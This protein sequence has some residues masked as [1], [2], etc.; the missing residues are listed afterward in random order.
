MLRFFRRLHIRRLIGEKL[1]PRQ[2][3]WIDRRVSMRRRMSVRQ[4]ERHEAIVR[5][6]LGRCR[7]EGCEGLEVTDEIRT[8]IAGHA[9]V[10]LLGSD[11]YYFD[12]VG[13]IIVF[14]GTIV[15]S[16]GDDRLTLGEAWPNGGI[17]L[18]W[19]EVRATGYH[20]RGRNVVIHE[21]AH[22][23]DGLDG[24]MGGSLHFSRREDQLRWNEISGE[25]FARLCE[26]VEDGYDTLL[27]PYGATNMAEFFAVTSEAFFED[28]WSLRDEHP[29]LYAMLELY[30]G[31]DPRCDQ[32]DHT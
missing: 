4:R 31:F 29:A 14:P 22:H 16:Q 30:Y 17:V 7:F 18:S 26:D 10:M 23:L 1:D 32:P 11:D 2:T 9:A 25:E 28:P 6:M 13:S 19:P 21:F 24:E 15:R 12:K 8:L 20:R 27:D 3:E 5:V